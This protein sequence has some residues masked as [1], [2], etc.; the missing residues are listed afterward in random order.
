MRQ[1]KVFKLKQA[2]WLLED[3]MEFIYMVSQRG[4][5]SPDTGERSL[6]DFIDKVQK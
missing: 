4:I 2:A 5:Q 6:K 1:D 3:G